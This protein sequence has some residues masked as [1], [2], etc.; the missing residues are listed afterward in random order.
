MTTFVQPDFPRV[1]GG[2]NRLTDVLETTRASLSRLGSPKVL[3]SILLTGGLSAAIV[4][5]E[6]V[7][8]ALTDGHLLL[9][10]VAMWLIVFGLLALFSDAISAWPAKLQAHLVTRKISSARRSEDERTWAAASSDPRLMAELDSALMRAQRD[11]QASGQEVP[12]WPF[13]NMPSRK[14]M[15]MRWA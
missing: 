14:T 5:A 13:A 1:H 9:A 15:P 10:W 6:Q 11:A 2:A 3:A 8:T 7:V 4:V 12:Y